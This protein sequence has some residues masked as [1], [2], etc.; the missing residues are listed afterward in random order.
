MNVTRFALAAVAT[1][2]TATLTGCHN[3]NDRNMMA[4]R[5]MRGSN[6]AFDHETGEIHYL[7]RYYPNEECYQSVYSGTWY[8]QTNEGWRYDEELPNSIASLGHYHLIELPTGLPGRMHASVSEE[9]PSA[10]VL[11]ARA[12]MY[13]IALGRDAA[14]AAPATGETR[15]V[16]VPTDDAGRP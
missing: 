3:S 2:G 5:A 6:I 16:N 4:E 13:D 1:L 7:Y 11:A 9:Y 12:R 8:F 10:E 14:D 15:I